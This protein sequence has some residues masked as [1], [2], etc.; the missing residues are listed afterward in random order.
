MG[1]PILTNL[2]CIC[3]NTNSSRFTV[4][5]SALT[6]NQAYLCHCVRVLIL[7]TLGYYNNTTQQCDVES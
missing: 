5:G 2:F 7:Y 4:N 3:G 1:L 6:Q